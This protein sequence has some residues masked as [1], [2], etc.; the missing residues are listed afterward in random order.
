MFLCME[1]TLID[2]QVPEDCG[3]EDQAPC[4]DGCQNGL[5]SVIVQ[6]TDG[7]LHGSDCFMFVAL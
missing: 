7:V 6:E 5:T 3:A 1:D 2:R 4:E